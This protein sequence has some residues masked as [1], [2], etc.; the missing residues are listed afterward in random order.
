MGVMAALSYVTEM[1]YEPSPALP[2]SHQLAW[3]MA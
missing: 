2:L 1:A 3:L